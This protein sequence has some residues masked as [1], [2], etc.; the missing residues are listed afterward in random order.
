[1][2]S[3]TAIRGFFLHCCCCIPS[4]EI[5]GEFPIIYAS[6]AQARAQAVGLKGAKYPWRPIRRMQ[7]Q[8][9]HFAYVLGEREIHV[10]ADIAI[11]QWQ[12][13]AGDP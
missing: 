2:R 6:A 5:V 9:P 7:R 13:L 1:M 12:Y 11:A 8:T 4:R 3:G 10:N